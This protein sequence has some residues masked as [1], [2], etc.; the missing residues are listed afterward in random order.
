MI[1][2]MFDKLISRSIFFTL[3]FSQTV[4]ADPPKGYEF[5]AYDIGLQQAMQENKKVF[6]YFGRYGCGYCKK[7]NVE[8]FSD[9]S[10]HALYSKNYVLIYVDA[11][12]GKRLQLP[13]GERITEAELG[14]RLNAFATPLFLYLEPDGKVVFRVPGFKTVEDFVYFDK[15]VQA[16]YYGKMSINEFLAQKEKLK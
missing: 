14:A 5:V 11:E 16:G 8:T 7:T 2:I 10:L 6:V 9:Q 4:L 13:N 3:L 1:T 15:Y 12:S